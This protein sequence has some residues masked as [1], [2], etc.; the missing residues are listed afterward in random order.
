[1][2][3]KRKM[4]KLIFIIVIMSALSLT[5][6]FYNYLNPKIISSLGENFNIISRKN[7]LL[8]HFIDVGQGDAIAV[9]LP[10]GKVML[11]D[12]GSKDCNVD[13]VNYIQENVLNSKI[14]NKIDYLI[15]TH[16]DSDHVG[17]TMKLLKNFKI[18][19]VYMPKIKSNSDTFKEINDYVTEN[20]N[21]QLLGDG[22]EIKT[23]KY[24]II[25]FEQQNSSNTNDSSQVVK[26]T[27]MN[28]SFLFAGDI[29]EEVEDDYIKKYQNEL[30]CD[31][32]K[33]AHHGSKSSTSQQFIDVV[34]PKF[35][36][37]SVGDNNDYNH[38]NEE[39]VNRLESNGVKIL[40][41]DNQGDIMFVMGSEHD[42]QVLCGTYFITNL[43]L[44][45]RIYILILDIILFAAMIVLIIQKEKIKN[46]HKK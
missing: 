32:L 21:Y 16:A 10:D 36:V 4:N 8:V 29:S 11:I 3:K 23:N 2:N 44:D 14:N 28:K 27:F 15:L 24:Q 25:F 19:L 41:T 43:P 37:L 42:F 34:T 38:P 12:N 33:V 26:L 7:N 6:V 17:G 20:C 35:A 46:K 5:C 9:N 22:F 39:I 13:Y 45:Y 30:D 1:M 18:N 40:R 31:V